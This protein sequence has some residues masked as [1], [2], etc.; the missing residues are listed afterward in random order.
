MTYCVWYYLSLESWEHGDW[1]SL[2]QLSVV[3]AS[4]R[5]YLLP[6]RCF[7]LPMRCLCSCLFHRFGTYISFFINYSFIFVFFII[8]LCRFNW[9]EFKL[10]YLSMVGLLRRFFISWTSLSTEVSSQFFLISGSFC[11]SF[12]HF[13]LFFIFIFQCVQWCLDCTS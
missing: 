8:L 12:A 5:L 13:F 3:A 6:G 4:Q 9:L 10:E 1:S 11:V 2:P 7:L